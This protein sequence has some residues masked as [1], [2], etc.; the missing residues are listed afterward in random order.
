MVRSFT[1]PLDRQLRDV[2]S[3]IRNYVIAEYVT[4]VP[5]QAEAIRVYNWPYRAVE[6]AL[7]NAVYHR[8]YQVHS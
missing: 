6:E 1:G 3:Y 2:L 7:S 8:S 5:N 4:K